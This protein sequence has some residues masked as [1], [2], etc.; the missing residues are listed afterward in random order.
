MD[1]CYFSDPRYSSRNVEQLLTGRPARA[2][3]PEH[4]KV[5]QYLLLNSG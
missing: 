1:S 3:L 2:L 4:R 5:A